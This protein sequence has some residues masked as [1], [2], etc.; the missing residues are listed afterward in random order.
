MEGWGG[1]DTRMDTHTRTTLDTELRFQFTENRQHGWASDPFSIL[2]KGLVLPRG[3]ARSQRPSG[4][5]SG[6]GVRI[7]L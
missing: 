5:F 2:P 1:A 7:E 3:V 6:C 4:K